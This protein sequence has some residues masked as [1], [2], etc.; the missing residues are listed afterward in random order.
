MGFYPIGDGL[1]AN[2]QRPSNPALIHAV[3]V[4]AQGLMANFLGVACFACHWR[5]FSSAY[6]AHVALATRC[7]MTD[8]DLLFASF[9]VRTFYHP[10]IL[11]YP[12]TLPLPIFEHLKRITTGSENFKFFTDRLDKAYDIAEKVTRVLDRIQNKSG[13]SELTLDFSRSQDLIFELN[14]IMD[15]IYSNTASRANT[16]AMFG[17]IYD[18][19]I[20]PNLTL[21]KNMIAVIAEELNHLTDQYVQR[22]YVL[23]E[24]LVNNNSLKLNGIEVLTASNLATEVIPYLQALV[25]LQEIIAR[26]EGNEWKE[27][28]IVRITQG[29]F[30]V[31]INGTEKAVEI[32]RELIEPWRRDHARQLAELQILEKKIAVERA[33]ADLKRSRVTAEAEERKSKLNLEIRQLQATITQM[34]LINEHHRVAIQKEKLELAIQIVEQVA[35][36]LPEQEKL[37]YVMRILE[38]LDTLIYSPLQL[39]LSKEIK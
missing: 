29:S 11:P 37:A 15:Q 19:E 20:R 6:F 24:R 23:P 3:H 16:S 27:P 25:H 33:E 30:N 18:N 8:F 4:Q 38:P 36:N 7:I 34:E 32:L 9:T 13:S 26:I 1:M 31:D 35:P 10:G 12:H 5:V 17:S 14:Q 22:V 28:N 39:K 2:T 21:S